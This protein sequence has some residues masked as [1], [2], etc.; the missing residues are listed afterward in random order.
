[1]G[2][3]S[4]QFLVIDAGTTQIRGIL[5]E[6]SPAGSSILRTSSL[7]IPADKRKTGMDEEEKASLY[8]S[9]LHS[10]LESHFPEQKNILISMPQDRVFIRDLELPIADERQIQHVLIHEMEGRL[11]IGMEKTE[12]IGRIW[13]KGDEESSL[14]CYS[15][16]HRRLIDRV[17][18]I[19][20]RSDLSL[21]LLTVDGP[22]I[23]AATALLDP[24]ATSNRSIAQIHLGERSTILNIVS[25]GK[26][27][28]SRSLPIGS[29]ELTGLVAGVLK[30]D[31]TEAEDWKRDRSFYIPLPGESIQNPEPGMK[32]EGISRK[33]YVK[34]LGLFREHFEGL[35]LEIERSFLAKE[36]LLVET[37]YL[38]GGG[39]NFTGLASFLEN[40]L[41]IPVQDYPLTI[42]GEPEIAEWIPAIG[43]FEEFKKRPLQRLDFLG[44]DFGRLLKRGEVHWRTFLP[45]LIVGGAGLVFFL[46]SFI[47][48]ILVERKQLQETHAR[49]L[50]VA[51]QIPGVS[52]DPNNAL[53]S[54][55]K[56]CQERLNSFRM[57]S[58]GVRVLELLYSLGQITP[59]PGE[60]SF[61]FKR[62]STSEK[63]IE[64][65]GEVQRLTEVT[66]LQES[67]EK[68]GE[69][70]RVEVKSDT[71]RDNV[72]LVRVKL[73]LKDPRQQLGVD[74]R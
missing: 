74:C 28:F 21:R 26:L 24:E 42:D 45:P 71:I 37:L 31:E 44:T 68:S 41:G 65:E 25:D 60:I 29:G 58:S 22:A 27:A 61:K 55:K 57:Q 12:V 49:I 34:L 69:Y 2:Y 50:A 35:A 62:L 19:L 6:K 15:A 9:Y 5:Y 51:R 66:V 32:P 48:G 72:V 40:I 4:E 16:E 23:A 43:I 30:L 36:D 52:S 13:R 20:Q 7:K 17:T 54:A 46:I 39:S 18:P 10:F 70:Q 38:S 3:F 64:I 8:A 59:A 47:L 56:L 63:E 73:I 11:P 1:M 67:F 53:A 33:D 14:L